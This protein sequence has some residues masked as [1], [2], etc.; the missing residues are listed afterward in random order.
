VS[1][2][3]SPTGP[4]RPETIRRRRLLAAAGGAVCVLALG[5]LLALLAFGGSS[6]HSPHFVPSGPPPATVLTARG[7]VAPLRTAP[8][9]AFKPLPAAVTRAA[10]LPLE[11]QVAQLFLVSVPG[12][13]PGA[14]GKL[15]SVNWGGFVLGRE[16]Y[17]GDQALAALTSAIQA[18]A[19]P[20]PAVP[21]LVAAS[22]EGGPATAFPGLPPRGEASIGATGTPADAGAQAQLAGT[23][24]RSLGLSMNLAPLA[25]VDTPGGALSGR[26][27]ST[28]P[29]AVAG[30]TKAAVSG[31]DSAGV[32]SAVGH[33]P[34]SGGASAD[35]DQMTAT[36]GGRL[37][38]LRARDLIPFAAVAATAPVIMMS[39]AAYVAFDG[40]TPA[41][42]LPQ[43]VKLLRQGLGFQG[44]VMSDDLDATLQPTSSDPGT[45][46]LQ[47]LQA[48]EDLLYISGPP[49]E[50]RAAYTAV[51][52]TA[53]ASPS[54][55]ALVH[56][57][58]LRVLSLK[59]RYGVLGP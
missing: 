9:P 26:L 33:F 12:Q 10:A 28:D 46:A 21:P 35:P 59:A 31:Y 38:D 6:A 44:V 4:P 20:P 13:T 42:L 40:V 8:A 5:I 50:A 11:Q 16:N 41:S 45:V 48:G 39:N 17:A 14:I 53:R 57:A 52:A 43:A 55:R 47:A 23:R 32:I 7:P 36:V 3:S 2:G 25:D 18:S 30:F 15:G 51:L 58:L 49:S 22:Q 56:E 37:A 54:L 19:P 27:F 34:G 24:L 29:A 1:A